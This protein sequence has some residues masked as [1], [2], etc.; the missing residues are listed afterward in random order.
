MPMPAEPKK[1]ERKKNTSLDYPLLVRNLL[2]A[3]G[4]A[5]ICKLP[6]GLYV[7][8]TPIGHLGDITLRALTTL[9]NADVVACEDSRVSGGML[10]KYGLKKTL[11]PYHDHN[12]EE[13]GAKILSLI[14]EGNA[15]AL[16]SDAGMPLISDPG[17][18]LV[19]DCRSRSI[20]VTVIPGANAAV[21]ALA[22]AGLPTDSFHFAGFLSPKKSAR[23]K[24]ITSFKT[25]PGTLT[26]YEAPPRLADT[27]ADLAE[28]F[29]GDR[30][31]VIARELTKLFEEMRHGTLAE[32]HAH[33]AASDVKGEIV[34]LV[35]PSKESEDA[36]IDIDTLIVEALQTQSLRDAVAIVTEMSGAKKTDV[37]ARALKITKDMK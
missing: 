12:T 31:A 19:R 18:R 25:V 8:A 21:T 36:E 2:E 32:L 13:A 24:E 30:E 10:A 17:Y 6:A 29:G 3:S 4:D 5:A 11:L 1:A 14:S 33:Y 35:G 22:G 26:F 20:L 34:I 16:I 7:V 27:L 28:I 15:V 23:Q 37:Y 9:L